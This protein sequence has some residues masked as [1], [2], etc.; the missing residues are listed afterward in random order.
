MLK[1]YLNQDRIDSNF[2]SAP[3]LTEKGYNNGIEEV[4]LVVNKEPRLTQTGFFGAGKGK[5]QSKGGG[6]NGK[7]N[8]GDSATGTQAPLFARSQSQQ[9]L[10]NKTAATAS[11]TTTGQEAVG[12]VAS[13]RP[14]WVHDTYVPGDGIRTDLRMLLP[15]ISWSEVTDELELMDLVD[16]QT[17][18]DV[19][20]TIV[21]EMSLTPTEGSRILTMIRAMTN[22]TPLQVIKTNVV[23]E[24]HNRARKKR[25]Q[26]EAEEEAGHEEEQ[27]EEQEAEKF[28]YNLEKS[29]LQLVADKAVEEFMEENLDDLASNVV[30]KKEVERIE[31]N[32]DISKMRAI[33]V[34]AEILKTGSEVV[35]EK[36]V[37]KAEKLIQKDSNLSS[38]ELTVMPKSKVS[39]R[40]RNREVYTILVR[41]PI[42]R[43]PDHHEGASPTG[44]QAKKRKKISEEVP[45][46]DDSV[47]M[48]EEEEPSV[49]S[50]RSR[51][52]SDDSEEEEEEERR[53]TSTLM[54]VLS[55]PLQILTG[56]R[57]TVTA[58]PVTTQAVPKTASI[59]ANRSGG[60]N[61]SQRAGGS[62]SSGAKTV[63]LVD[64]TSEMAKVFAYI[65]QSDATKG[66]LARLRHHC[67][68]RTLI[69]EVETR[70]W[71]VRIEYSQL[72]QYWSHLVYHRAIVP[73]KF[74]E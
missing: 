41:R 65:M 50:R 20:I 21:L 19:F 56:T 23:S 11:T 14:P 55:A 62:A 16:R 58:A 69:S 4:S 13:V 8:K 59:L 49:C 18:Q 22:N 36:A 64:V 66:L 61:N 51:A 24:S 29:Q 25:Q 54:S 32:N 52:G 48:Y 57:S 2:L 37:E 1:Q 9:R 33:A 34:S 31:Y 45:V 47:E 35:V 53:D 67:D 30:K 12:R 27:G 60:K 39:K 7:G 44:Q 68:L 6:N 40:N 70:V 38:I 46:V 42:M 10:N 26:E 73:V 3:I 63:R 15:E 17:P 74:D 72:K 5:E 28:V 71:T 43:H